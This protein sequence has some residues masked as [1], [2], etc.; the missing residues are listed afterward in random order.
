M[1]ILSWGRCTAVGTAFPQHGVLLL[2]LLLRGLAVLFLPVA[3][4][5]EGK[6]HRQHRQKR[7]NAPVHMESLLIDSVIAIP[8][9]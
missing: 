8:M 9:A 1:V 3:A 5:T 7:R 4:G 6:H 2:R